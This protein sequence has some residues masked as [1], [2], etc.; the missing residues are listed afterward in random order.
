M[1][2]GAVLT[3]ADYLGTLAAARSL[4]RAGIQVT[5][6]DAHT[7]APASWSRYVAR[8]LACPDVASEPERFLEWLITL[9]RRE[10]GQVLLATSDDVAWLF[11]RHRDEL[12][13][14]FRLYLP[15]FDIMYTLLNKWR[16]YRAC[17]TLGVEAP[18][19]W[20]GRGESALDE[21][22]DEI[23]FPLVIKPQTQAF[24][25]PHQKGRFVP[26]REDLAPLYRDFRRA[27][28]YAGTLLEQD[29]GAREPV[30][31]AFSETARDGIYNL[32]G[33][34]DESGDLFV[35]Y[36]SRKVLQWPP[37]LGIG[38]CFEDA[39]VLPEVA[40]KLARFCR[41]LGYYGAFE[42]EYVASR[43]RHLLIDFNPRFYGQMGFEV[44]RGLDVPVL[45]YLAAVGAGGELR[46]RTEAVGTSRRTSQDA[47]CNRTELEITLQLLL[48][49]GRIRPHEERGWRAWLEG[50]RRSVTDA[51]LDHDDWMPGI[52]ET[53]GSVLRRALHPRSAWRAARSG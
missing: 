38:L 50:H 39:P 25:A 16:L 29:P 2:P 23:T 24:L 20:L 15:S 26:R 1:P 11:A 19:T 33:F 31:Q 6:A 10:P 52:V 21:V 14:H 5:M 41:T 32:S 3:M 44:A 37:R 40:S 18:P 8:T 12:S 35:A 49:A 53:A 34:V 47:Y 43:G 30:L 13:Q 4:G 22:A 28:H 45:A 42:V 27:T 17:T 36:A 9:G 46:R 7:F 51:V 48:L